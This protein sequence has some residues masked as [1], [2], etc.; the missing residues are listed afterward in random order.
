MRKPTPVIISK[1]SEE[2]WS[3]WKAKSILKVPVLI[4]VNKGSTGK[5][6]AAFTCKKSITLTIKEASIAPLPMMPIND[7]DNDLLSKPLIRKPSSGNNGT[8]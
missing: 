8:K 2:S 7:L 1:K 6:P 3:T 5:A 4:K